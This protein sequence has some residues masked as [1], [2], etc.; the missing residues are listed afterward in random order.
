MHY[1]RLQ[2]ANEIANKMFKQYHGQFF[3]TLTEE[4]KTLYHPSAEAIFGTYRKT[5]VLCSSPWCCG[6]PR[7]RGEK[8]IQERKAPRINEEWN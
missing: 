7:R 2:R 1:L 8:T 3:E 4:E 5:K 6:N